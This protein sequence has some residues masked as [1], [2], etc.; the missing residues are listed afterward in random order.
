MPTEVKL[1]ELAEGVDR[2][3][4]LAVLVKEGDTITADT[5]ILDLETGKA[6]LSVPAGAAGKVKRVLVKVGDSIAVGQSLLELEGAGKAGGAGVSPVKSKSADSPAG[7]QTAQRA[8]EHADS[9]I[10]LPKER[11]TP[12]AKQATFSPNTAVATR[13]NGGHT[14][15]E[16]PAGPAVRRIARELGIDLAQVRGSGR[17]GRITVEDLDPYIS[18]YIVRRGGGAVAGIEPI[19]LPDFSKFGPIRREKADT[20]RQKIA[21]KMAQAWATIPHVHQFHEVDVT[22][23]LKLQQRQ[24]ERVKEAG[25]SL[26][27]TVF[28]IKA[29]A[30][31]LKDFP[32][33]NCSYDVAAQEI[34]HKDYMHI[35]VA[36]DTP[37]G[38]IVP[39]IRD[40]DKKSVMEI[41][42][43][44]TQLAEKTRQRKVSL[45]DL[46]GGT[47]TITNLGG[48]GGSHFTPII[49][50]PEV[51]ILGIGRAA[52]RVVCVPCDAKRKAKV[53]SPAPAKSARGPHDD[54]DSQKFEPRD[55]LPLCLAYDHRVIDGADGARFIMRLGE[56]LEN[57]ESIF[58]GL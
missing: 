51:A 20:L 39:V 24:K 45:T 52:K 37:A 25:G 27:L 48:I 33:F 6:T 53:G 10:E 9:D 57:F 17:N 55:Y 38:L 16:I 43:E 32:Q 11:E 2:G 15:Q 18:G 31:A 21:K 47:F 36:V 58:L 8:R 4:V 41:S 30:M 54:G 3:D 7:D 23:L 29:V 28:A 56:I 14:S 44:L 13:N 49:N 50:A 22:D 12:P 42:K 26:T 40:A 46:Q 1:P 5:P 35:G 19:E 34:V